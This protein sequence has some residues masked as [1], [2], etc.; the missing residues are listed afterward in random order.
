MACFRIVFLWFYPSSK[1]RILGC[2][3]RSRLGQLGV[4]ELAPTPSGLSRF[5]KHAF[6]VQSKLK[7]LATRG[8]DANLLQLLFTKPSNSI[9]HL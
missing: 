2:M 5:V 8:M 1:T 3:K 6:G 4:T 7:C 9:D